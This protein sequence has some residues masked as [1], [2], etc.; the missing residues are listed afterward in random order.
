MDGRLEIL[1]WSRDEL[2][3]VDSADG[4]SNHVFGS[5]D[6]DLSAVASVDGDR[7]PDLVLPSADRDE[8][9]MVTAAGGK[10]RT[11]ATLPLP[12]RVVT[13]IGILEK[14]TR[15][16]FA[17]GLDDGSLLGIAKQ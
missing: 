6:Q 1:A 5:E 17:T 9:R 8:M 2:K 16:S 10:V 14:G 3:V 11:L 13:N 7:I 4:F 12:A 15:P